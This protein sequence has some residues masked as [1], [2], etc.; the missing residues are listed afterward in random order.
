MTPLL[1]RVEQVVWSTRGALSRRRRTELPRPAAHRTGSLRH[2]STAIVQN[3]PETPGQDKP[4][5]TPNRAFGWDLEGR[6]VE[7]EAAVIRDSAARVLAGASFSAE[8][9]R[10]QEAGVWTPGERWYAARVSR[11]LTAPR[12]V[13]DRPPVRGGTPAAIL[14]RATYEALVASAEERQ[15]AKAGRHAQYPNALLARLLECHRCGAELKLTGAADKRGYRCPSNRRI[16]Q[17]KVACGRIQINQKALDAFV[18]ERALAWWALDSAPFRAQG[19]PEVARAV[20]D[21]QVV[22]EALEGLR[23]Q[24]AAGLITNEEFSHLRRRMSDRQKTMRERITR[25]KETGLPPVEGEAIYDWWETA[26]VT[27]RNALVGAVYPR[28]I[29]GPVTRPGPARGADQIDPGRVTTPD[30]QALRLPPG[31]ED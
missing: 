30:G 14:D 17:G 9:R 1:G 18:T 13:G 15:R 25:A 21:L 31:A 26:E 16:G 28:L 29:V 12:V 2:M 19:S 4:A 11:M 3:P 20:A 7:E 6:I 22:Q 27:E 23:T 5:R 8:A 24:L 10:L